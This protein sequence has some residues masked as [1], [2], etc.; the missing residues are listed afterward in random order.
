[1]SARREQ[2]EMGVLDAITQLEKEKRAEQDYEYLLQ[3]EAERL[4]IQGYQPQ[5]SHLIASTGTT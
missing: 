1:M 3:Q 5:V 4:K 2:Q